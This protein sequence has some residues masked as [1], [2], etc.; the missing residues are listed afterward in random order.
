MATSKQEQLYSEIVQYYNFAD[1]LIDTIEETKGNVPES[2]IKAVEKI[3]ED[4]EK[5]A[6]ELS[7]QFVEF[8]KHGDSKEVVDSMRSSLNN[9]IAK[10][11]ECRN[12]IFQIYN[13]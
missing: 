9:I 2:Q 13:H 11:E 12:Q 10:I 8:V 3:V 7:G 4:L 5:Y 6:D 1:K